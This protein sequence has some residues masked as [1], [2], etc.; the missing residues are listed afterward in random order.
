MDEHG[1]QRSVTELIAQ[2]AVDLHRAGHTTGMA[3]D[4][5]K[6]I[7]RGG[8]AFADLVADRIHISRTA[9]A[10]N[11]RAQSLE[12]RLAD[13]QDTADMYERERNASFDLIDQ[14]EEC[15]RSGHPDQAVRHIAGFN[16]RYRSA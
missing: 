5:S 10:H 8:T 11:D 2:V 4:L 16:N 6:K 14:V 1:R 7:T 12:R 9:S 13:L 3:D 15:I